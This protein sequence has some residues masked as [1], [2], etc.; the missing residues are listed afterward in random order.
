[1]KMLFALP[2]VLERVFVMGLRMKCCAVS[3]VR[4]VIIEVIRLWKSSLLVFM[5]LAMVFLAE[6]KV[7]TSV[8]LMS[9]L[10]LCVL[11]V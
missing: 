9:L 6:V 1:M 2:S 3:L 11:V 7:L 8:L 4:L 10:I 5:K